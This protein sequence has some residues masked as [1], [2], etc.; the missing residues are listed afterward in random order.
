[1]AVVV[2]T[3]DGRGVVVPRHE[4]VKMMERRSI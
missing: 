3:K 4:T 2:D 1:V